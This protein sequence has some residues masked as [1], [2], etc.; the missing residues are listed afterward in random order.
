M[1]KKRFIIILVILVVLAGAVSGVVVY[2]NQNTGPIPMPETPAVTG[3]GSTN[4]N[5]AEAST[6]DTVSTQHVGT[7]N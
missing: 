4:D 3:A 7:V 1:L 6:V 2:L 5:V